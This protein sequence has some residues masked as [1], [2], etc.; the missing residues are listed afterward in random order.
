MKPSPAE[1]ERERAF[2]QPAA[3]AAVSVVML[4]VL[5]V[6][7]EQGSGLETGGTESE[8]LLS[9]H[10][11]S[12]ALLLATCIRSLAFLLLAIPFLHLFRAAK[13]RSERVRPEMVGFVYLGPALL[14]VQGVLSWLA[15]RS[16]A[17]EFVDQMVGNPHPVALAE[18][19]VD[20]NSFHQI[21]SYLAIPAVFALAVGMF[22]I[23][24]QAMRT[25]LLTR[26]VGSL[27]MALGAAMILILP[28]ALLL[29]TIWLV[30]LG[31]TFIGKVPGGRPPAWEMGEAIPWPT[32]GE[33][34][35]KELEASGD[36]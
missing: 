25:G 36:E 15:T 23:S 8:Q 19:L 28:I 2:A 14:A 22:Y 5:S 20:D 13:S 27:G 7:I 16:V 35:A 9:F 18:R 34:A 10:D 3:I 26:F 1:L 31:L 17:D 29:T 24:L 11:N 6:I 12:G 32:P 21:A 4:Y 33:K 30:F